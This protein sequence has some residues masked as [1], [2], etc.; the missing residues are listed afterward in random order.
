MRG[1]V[2]K[3]REDGKID[4]SLE[5]QGYGSIEP[6]AQKILQVLAKNNGFLPLHD[7]SDP[8]EITRRLEMS[9]KTFKKAIGGLYKEKRITIGEDGIRSV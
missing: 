8:A 9:K 6:N 4:L 1:F 7:K 2:K 3:V 5:K